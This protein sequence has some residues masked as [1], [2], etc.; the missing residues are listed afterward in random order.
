LHSPTL[1]HQS[2][3]GPRAV[4]PIDAQGHPLPHMWLEQYVPPCILFGWWSTPQ[5]LGGSG[6]LFCCSPHE[7][8]KPLSS[9]SASSNSS[10]GEPQSSV[11]WLAA[12]IHLC[13]CQT[14]AKP[15]RRQP[16]QAP[17]SKHFPAS[18]IASGFGDYIWDEFLGGQS[19]DG[20]SFSLSSMFFLLWV[21]CFPF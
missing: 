21:F 19:M 12:N 7:A 3:S 8:T 16:N 4:P 5:E 11:Q 14:L 18:T 17:V 6:Q 1:G 15:F 10:I 13:I 9:F 2:P 20:L